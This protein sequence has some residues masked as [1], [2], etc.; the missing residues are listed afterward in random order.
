M[1]TI[2]KFFIYLFACLLLS[3]LLL[4]LTYP[5]FEGIA[6][7][8]PDR[9]L[10]RLGLLFC[11]IGL[12]IFLVNQNLSSRISLGFAK[13]SQS[14]L[15][16]L[17]TAL[18]IGVLILVVLMF[19]FVLLDIRSIK[20]E[21]S[22]TLVKVIEILIASFVSG[23]VVGLI[24]EF[25]FRGPM[26]TG[27]RK[28]LG[29]WA[30]ALSI[31]FFYSSI[32]FMRP[33]APSGADITIIESLSMFWGGITNISNVLEHPD[34]FVGLLIAGVF[35]SMVR[36]RGKSLIWAIGIHAGWVMTIK[37]SNEFTSVN[38]DS[39][40]YFLVGNDGVVGWA[41]TIWLGSIAA[42]YW[43]VS[44]IKLNTKKSRV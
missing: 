22:L 33:I 19:S 13:N 3:T 31:G 41:S 16:T 25:F 26:Q 12:P 32:H 35:L 7:T 42:I 15:I 21:N 30:S 37:I 8:N 23:I 39:F 9:L 10:Y 24:E 28:E 5:L 38:Y 36:E 4:P 43:L 11:I 14:E 1:T 6:S 34:R 29:F 27:A 44:S 40:Y 20:W 2:L 18:I 17:F